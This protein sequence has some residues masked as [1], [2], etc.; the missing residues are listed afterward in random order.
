MVILRLWPHDDVCRRSHS[1]AGSARDAQ[2][3][4]LFDDVPTAVAFPWQW[5]HG[6]SPAAIAQWQCC[7]GDDPALVP[8]PTPPLHL[9]EVPGLAADS[10]AQ[11]LITVLRLSGEGG[12]VEG[13]RRLANE[14]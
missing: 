1:N 4:P 11:T 9:R 14:Q 12:G 3:K 10:A 5:C 7:Y 13:G 6:C 8:I 2:V